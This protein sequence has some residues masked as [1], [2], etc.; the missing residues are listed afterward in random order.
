MNIQKSMTDILKLGDALY[1]D[2]EGCLDIQPHQ[3]RE[4]DVRGESERVG[5]W[6]VALAAGDDNLDIA[7]ASDFGAALLLLRQRLIEKLDARIDRYQT[8]RGGLK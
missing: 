1:E 4:D 5:D 8:L 2:L 7:S 3:V 6:R